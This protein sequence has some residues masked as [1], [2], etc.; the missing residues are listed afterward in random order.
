MPFLVGAFCFVA[1]SFFP[2]PEKNKGDFFSSFKKMPTLVVEL[3]TKNYPYPVESS[4]QL[5]QG[6]I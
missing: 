5:Y 4:K 3:M 1:F 6:F 2:A